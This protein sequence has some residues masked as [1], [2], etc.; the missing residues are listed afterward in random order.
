MDTVRH[1]EL[2]DLIFQLH[3]KSQFRGSV[4]EKAI[5]V[6]VKEYKIIVM[7]KAVVVVVV[8]V[9]VMI[10]VVVSINSFWTYISE[11]CKYGTSPSPNHGNLFANPTGSRM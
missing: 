8:M 5:N 7:A 9:M 10:V 6:T 1:V 3:G 2:I 4:V 11:S